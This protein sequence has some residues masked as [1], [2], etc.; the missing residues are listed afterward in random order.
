[1]ARPTDR[2]NFVIVGNH[3]QL[4]AARAQAA[5]INGANDGF[6]AEVYAPTGTD[7]R[8]KVVIGANLTSNEAHALKRKALEKGLGQAYIWQLPS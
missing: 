1:L 3:D 6:T 2:I 5:E 8:Y 4:E 7:P